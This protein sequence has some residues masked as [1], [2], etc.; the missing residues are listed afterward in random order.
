MILTWFGAIYVWMIDEGL[1]LERDAHRWGRMIGRRVNDEHPDTTV[2]KEGA[3]GC[4]K[5]DSKLL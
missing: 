4:Q 1:I 5:V 2:M 3:Q